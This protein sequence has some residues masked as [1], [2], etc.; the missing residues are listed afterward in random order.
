MILKFLAYGGPMTHEQAGDAGLRDTGLIKW[1]EKIGLIVCIRRHGERSYFLNHLSLVSHNL[2]WMS[3]TRV[4]EAEKNILYFFID[5]PVGFQMGHRRRRATSQLHQ[6]SY[7]LLQYLKL[8]SR[9]GALKG[10]LAVDWGCGSGIQAI[11]LIKLCP[12][13][14]QVIGVDVDPHCLWLFNINAA[15]NQCGPKCRP[16]VNDPAGKN[17]LNA[18]A[19]R[20]IH[21][22]VSNPPFNA[23]PP[24]CEPLN[25][26]YGNGGPLGIRH[27]KH[28]IEQ[29]VPHL[30]AGGTISCY[31]TLARLNTGDY[32]LVRDCL[33]DEFCRTYG[34]TFSAKIMDIPDLHLSADLYAKRLADLVAKTGDGPSNP[35]NPLTS[36]IAAYFKSSG[37]E[38]FVP[39]ILTVTRNARRL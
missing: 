31:C 10:P 29:S 37:I 32:A 26:D 5:L 13:I 3:Q 21:L 33:T 11:S 7:I 16:V 30:A 14:E 39:V 12:E 17:V 23:I 34:I 15:L 25:S 19:G 8:F 35:G 20:Q 36:E 22:A 28:F 27:L 1:L 6:T 2:N 4:E 24:V 18:M 9:T 38:R